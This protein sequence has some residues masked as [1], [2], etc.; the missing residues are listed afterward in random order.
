MADDD[1]FL[2]QTRGLKSGAWFEFKMPEDDFERAKLSWIS[3]FTSH[4]QFVNRRGLK[5]CERGMEELACELRDGRTVLLEQ[6]P[7]FD[8]ALGA[9]VARLRSSPLDPEM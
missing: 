3:P 9:V 7:L 5:V 8:R 2:V 6:A 1:P 4:L